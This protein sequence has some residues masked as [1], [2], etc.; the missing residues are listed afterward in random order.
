MQS[1]SIIHVWMIRY[2]NLIQ[3][4]INIY[5]YIVTY[6]SRIYNY[7]MYTYTRYIDIYR[8]IYSIDVHNK[9]IFS[10]DVLMS[11]NSKQPMPTWPFITVVRDISSFIRGISSFIRGISYRKRGA[12]NAK[13]EHVYYWNMAQCDGFIPHQYILACLKNQNGL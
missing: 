12:G 4:Y 13:I 11:P 8:Y 1:S 9:N 10:I 6:L 2:C 3:M 5:K 7:Y